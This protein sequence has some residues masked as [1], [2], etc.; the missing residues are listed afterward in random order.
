MSS[1]KNKVQ[2][3]GNL[4]NDPE[5][6]TFDKSKSKVANFSIATNETYKNAKGEKITDTQWHNIVVWGKLANVVEKYLQKGSEIALEGKLVSRSYTTEAGETRYV[7]EVKVSEFEMVS[8]TKQVEES[9][10]ESK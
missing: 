5:I 9:T 2:L 10:E 6:K 7:T 4:G 3:W 8:G 1:I